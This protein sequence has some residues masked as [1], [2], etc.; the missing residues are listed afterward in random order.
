M[1]NLDKHGI[2][3]L[4]G[5]DAVPFLQGYVTCDL[6]RLEGT[7]GLGAICNIQG[8]MLTSFIVIR[9]DNSLLLKM[10]RAL[11]PET[12]RFLSRYI[13]FSKATMQ[14]ISDEWHLYGAADLDAFSDKVVADSA[15]TPGDMPVRFQDRR[16]VLSL[17]WGTEIWSKSKRLIKVT[18]IDDAWQAAQ[19]DH[20]IAWVTEKTSGAF[21]PQMMNYHKLGAVDFDKGC[22]L[23][24]E[25]VA[26][27][28]YRGA[29][30]RKLHRVEPARGL[31]VGDEVGGGMIVAASADAA[32]AV[33]SNS[34]EGPLE[35]SLPD[36]RVVTAT[37]L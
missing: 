1:I 30:K 35:V 3:C 10:S 26:R 9:H 4:T 8:R 11:V 12:I 23:G 6:S 31:E 37:P 21:L 33:L 5:K 19:V 14:D 28:Q 25:V 13:V 17:P 34:A 27:A 22:Y 32:L 7:A 24:Q 15:G 18:G 29:L 2:L 20:G 16:L 36:G